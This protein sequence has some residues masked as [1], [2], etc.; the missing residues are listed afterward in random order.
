MTGTEYRVGQIADIPDGQLHEITIEKTPILFVRRG[1]QVVA[2]GARCPHYGAPLEKGKLCDGRL[3][4]PWHCAAFDIESGELLDPPALDGFR[5]Y[6]IRVEEGEVFVQLP[7]EQAENDEGVNIDATDAEDDRLF[8]I[9]GTGGAGAAAAEALREFGFRGRVLLIGDEHP[10]YDRP[11]C[12]KNYLAGQASDGKL[13]LRSEAFYRKKGIKC[14]ARK[15][16]SVDVT[17]RVIV[18]EK[19]QGITA[20]KILLATGASPISLDVPGHSLSGVHT[21]RSATDSRRIREKAQTSRHAVV[22][23]GG[24]IGM[25][26]AASLAEHNC[27]VTLVSRDHVPMERLIGERIGRFLQQLHEKNGT[28]FCLGREVRRCVGEDIVNGVEL[29]DGSRLPADL[30]VVGIGVRPNTELVQMYPKNPDGS[31]DVDQYLRLND[32]IFAAGDIAC[33][34]DPYFGQRLRVEHW[35]VAQQQGRTA[36]RNMLGGAQP[37]DGVPFFWT[38]EFGVSLAYAGYATD[39]DEI[40]YLGTP[41]ELDFSAYYVRNNRVLAVFGTQTEAPSVS[42]SRCEQGVRLWPAK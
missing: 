42:W 14:V 15:V 18:F 8:A 9:V 29:D 40:I 33:Y 10:P 21:L 28:R 37:F 7:G 2:L 38:R 41:E 23:G 35:R 17:S 11:S 39:W 4:C 36:A 3:V 27:R 13:P 25:E 5:K 24:L 34:P 16:S 20:D 31:L 32:N 22:V 12:S 26:V 30:V 6:P 1:K 19:S